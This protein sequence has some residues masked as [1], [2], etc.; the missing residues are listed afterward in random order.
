M[1][2]EELKSLPHKKGVDPNDWHEVLPGLR[3]LAYESV[4]WIKSRNLPILFTSIIRPKIQGVSKSDTHA[5]GRAFDLSVKGW[6]ADQCLEFEQ[7]INDNFAE[8]LGAISAS[9]GRPRA[10]LFHV[11]TAP[12]QHIQTRRTS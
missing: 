10:C 3:I 6:S 11:G 9:D 1:N 7:Y 5:Q 2:I 12:H 4:E 8:N